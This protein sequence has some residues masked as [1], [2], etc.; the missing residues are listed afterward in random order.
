M[1]PPISVGI[2]MGSDSDVPVVEKAKDMMC[3]QSLRTGKCEAA[4]FLSPQ[5]EQ[6]LI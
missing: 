1:K 2:I 6:L 4:R 5:L 3:N